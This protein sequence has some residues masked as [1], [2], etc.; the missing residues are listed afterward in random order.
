MLS[1]SV[2]RVSGCGTASKEKHWS[3]AGSQREHQSALHPERAPSSR[4]WG[5]PRSC[6]PLSPHIPPHPTLLGGVRRAGSLLALC[7]ASKHLT[8]VSG[9]TMGNFKFLY[10]F[11]VFQISA[12]RM[13]YSFIRKGV[14]KENFTY[15][16]R[17]YSHNR[18]RVP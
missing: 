17:T 2:E 12:L 15:S 7:R 13:Y 14:V 11:Y 16:H 3:V 10:S 4:L 5:S 8:S 1:N 18:L 6:S 9:R